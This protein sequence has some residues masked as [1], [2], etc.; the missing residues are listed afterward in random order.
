[1]KFPK[2]LQ[3]TKDHEWLRIE[4]DNAVT[5]KGAINTIAVASAILIK[6][7]AQ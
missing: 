1:M 4:G 7:T 6:L 3:Y 5:I 2:E